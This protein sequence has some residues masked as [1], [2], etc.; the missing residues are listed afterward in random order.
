VTP[1]QT[2]TGTRNADTLR[3]GEG[4][5]TLSGLG[6]NDTLIG[7]D[8]DDRL[9]GGADRDTLTGGNGADIFVFDAPAH[10][11]VRTA[12]DRITDFQSGIDLIDLS[13][14]DANRK[15]AENDAF[16]FIGGANFSKKAGELRYSTTSSGTYVSGD[17]NGDGVADFE[18]LLVNKATPVATD[19]LL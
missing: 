15:T 5:D 12:A 3:G 10:T 9:N 4:G 13:A 17:T 16:T 18:I 7:G 2:L 14:I 8:G 6:G 19:F 11:G 1:G